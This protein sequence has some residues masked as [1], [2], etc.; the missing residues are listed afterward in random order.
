[1]HPGWL[2]TPVQK[3]SMATPFNFVVSHVERKTVM[4]VVLNDSYD[5]RLQMRP[6]EHN[7]SLISW[8]GSYDASK[9]ILIEEIQEV[10]IAW[11]TSYLV[12]WSTSN[13]V[14]LFWRMIWNLINWMLGGQEI[15]L[16]GMQEMMILREQE[17]YLLQK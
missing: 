6:Y 2:I 14:L 13:C 10:K 16:L 11:K 15:I 12:P 8:E 4:T 1:M 3:R 9:K 7:N 5:L 17:T